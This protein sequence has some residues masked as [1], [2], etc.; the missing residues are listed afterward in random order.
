MNAGVGGVTGMKTRAEAFGSDI[1][2]TLEDLIESAEALLEE[3]QDQQGAAAETLR[4]RAWATIK[5][6]RSRLADMRPQVGDLAT[7]TLRGTLKFVR[8]DPWR[9]VALGALLVLALGVLANA[10]DDEDD[11]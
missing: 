11:D 4:A 2:D 9:A 10:G 8:R 6:A 7:K 1:G 3:L 5:S